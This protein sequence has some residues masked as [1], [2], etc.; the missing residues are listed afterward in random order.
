MDVGESLFL[1]LNGIKAADIRSLQ[2]LPSSESISIG[3]SQRLLSGVLG[4]VNLERLIFGCLETDIAMNLS[5][6]VIERRI[7]LESVDLSN[8]SVEVLDSLL[9]NESVSVENEDSLL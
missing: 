7:D 4:N 2:L 1:N 8:L 6:L 9:L 5:D 3:G